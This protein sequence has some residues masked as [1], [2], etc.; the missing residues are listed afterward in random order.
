ME[1]SN[2]HV[3]RIAQDIDDEVVCCPLLF[4]DV[5]EGLLLRASTVSAKEQ[6]HECHPK[7]RE[8]E[9]RAEEPHNSEAADPLNGPLLNQLFWFPARVHLVSMDDCTR[10]LAQS[11][12]CREAPRPDAERLMGIHAPNARSPAETV[13]AQ[14]TT[15]AN[16]APLRPIIIVSHRDMF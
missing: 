12:A 16:T 9:H 2:H 1:L 5:H 4:H 13:P 8:I 6:T 7:H 3:T 10:R 14:N 11:C 15:A